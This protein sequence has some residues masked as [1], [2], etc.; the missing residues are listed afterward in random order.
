MKAESERLRDY[1]HVEIHPHF[2]K[3]YF[4]LK[5]H[6]YVTKQMEILIE[7]TSSWVAVFFFSKKKRK[8][9]TPKKQKIFPIKMG[10]I[11]G[12]VFWIENRKR[13]KT[14]SHTLWYTN[15]K[16]YVD[17]SLIWPFPSKCVW[18]REKDWTVNDVDYYYYV[19]AFQ[20]GTKTTWWSLR[21]G[22]CERLTSFPYLK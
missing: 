22:Y 2:F 6:Q 21:S 7:W 3:N 8:K 17:I 15:R 1:F 12:H 16:I 11:N 13:K 14:A 20:N 10:K 5:I 4:F 9:K 19:C 18:E